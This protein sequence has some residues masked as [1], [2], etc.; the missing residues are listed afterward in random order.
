MS[1]EP[2]GD[3]ITSFDEVDFPPRPDR[4]TQRDEDSTEIV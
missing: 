3:P 2:L 1:H 4:P